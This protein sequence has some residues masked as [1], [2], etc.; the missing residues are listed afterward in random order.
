MSTAEASRPIGVAIVGWVTIIQGIFSL[1]A[2]IGLFIERNNAELIE[3]IGVSSGTIGGYA[4]AA[5]I[6]GALALIVGWSLLQGAGWA[7]L[8]VAI[9]QVAHVAG[10]VYVLFAWSGQHRY[11]GIG[12]IVVG[13]VVLFLLFNPRADQY[14]AS[15]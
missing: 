15:R 4:W 8:L 1:A 2:G 6:W 13:L 11:E 7:R 3:H 12:Q 10:G 14:Y 9:A 5:I